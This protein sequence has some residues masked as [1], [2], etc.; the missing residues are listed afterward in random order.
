VSVDSSG[1][2]G[3]H[4]SHWPSISA[5]GRYVAFGSDASNLVVGDT[6]YTHDVFIHDRQTGQTTRVSVDSSGVQGNGLSAFVS[7]S[8]DGRYAAF[9]SQASNLTMWDTNRASDCFVHDCRTGRTTRVSVSSAGVQGDRDSGNAVLSSD[10]RFVAFSSPATNLILGDTNDCLDVFVH[11]RRTRHTSRVSVNSLGGQGNGRSTEPAISADGRYVAFRSR[12]SDLVPGDT[13]DAW[14]VFV[15]DRQTG[16]TSRAS[17]DSSGMEGNADSLRP[18]IS[19]DGR[20]VA[21]SSVADNLVLGDHNGEED[22]FVHDLQSGHTTR[23]SVDSGGR[24]ANRRNQEPRLS[25]DGRYVA[26]GS[27]AFNLVPGD[28]N[29]QRDIFVHDRRS[30]LTILASV[31]SAGTQGNNLSF[32]PALSADGRILAFTSHATNLVPSDT[33]YYSDVFVH[34]CGAAGIGV[35]QVGSCPG[36]IIVKIVDATPHGSVAVLTGPAGAFVQSAP[37]CQGISLNLNPPTLR[38]LRTTDAAGVSRFVFNAPPPVC[39]LSLQVVDVSTCTA[40]NTIV[41]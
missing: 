24:E 29:G 11:D 10:G 16:R 35:N 40:S 5:D 26:F 30:G 15:H 6:N 38:S 34:D 31:D 33:N 25:A 3:D 23:T 18:A 20:I 39:G 14:D 13:N 9:D 7:I 4:A 22:I 19:S 21:F 37:P 8:A 27:D 2:Q 36:A 17:V 41:L 12:A 1:A 28:I 32:F